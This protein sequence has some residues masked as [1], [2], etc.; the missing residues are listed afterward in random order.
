MLKYN[1]IFKLLKTVPNTDLAHID[2]GTK[3]VLQVKSPCSK[4]SKY[5]FLEN[6]SEPKITDE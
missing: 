4:K 6:M 1:L 2:F 5:R 3:I